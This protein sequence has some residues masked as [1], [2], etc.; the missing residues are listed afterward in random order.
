M[1][2]QNSISKKK[3]IENIYLGNDTRASKSS[4]QVRRSSGR[5][6]EEGSGAVRGGPPG[7]QDESDSKDGQ[8]EVSKT[9]TGPR[10]SVRTKAE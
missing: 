8:T 10:Y 3:F 7:G 9:N 6:G 4:L 2:E 5:D 1:V